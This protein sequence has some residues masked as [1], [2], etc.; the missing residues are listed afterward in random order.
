MTL[1]YSGASQFIVFVQTQQMITKIKCFDFNYRLIDFRFRIEI[2]TPNRTS[3]SPQR[4]AKNARDGWRGEE[5]APAFEDGKCVQVQ[6]VLQR[7]MCHLL[8]CTREGCFS[9]CLIMLP[10]VP[11]PPVTR[12]SFP[13]HHHQGSFNSLR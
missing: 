10:C 1:V 8:S 4:R 12:K 9:L 7:V 11:S 5:T 2:V 3:S 6:P 13:L